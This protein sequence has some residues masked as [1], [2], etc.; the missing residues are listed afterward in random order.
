[1]TSPPVRHANSVDEARYLFYCATV[2]TLACEKLQYTI[3]STL[4]MQESWLGKHSTF[5]EVTAGEDL[6]RYVAYMRLVTYGLLELVEGGYRFTHSGRRAARKTEDFV[7]EHM[8][9]LI[10]VLPIR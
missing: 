10:L 2:S 8:E 9:K 4:R 6:E 1:M 5:P 3:M 7:F